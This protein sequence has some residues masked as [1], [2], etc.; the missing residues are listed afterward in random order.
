MPEFYK[1]STCRYQPAAQPYLDAIARGV[2]YKATSRAFLLEGTEYSQSYAGAKLLWRKQ[3]K[4]RDPTDSNKCPFWS[5]YF[6]EPCQSCN[7]RI[8]DSVSMEIDAI[9]F[10][11]DAEGKTLAIHIEMKRDGEP[12]KFGQSEAYRPRAECYRDQRRIRETLLA[13]NYF[14]AVLFHG[15]GTDIPL[16]KSHFDSVI[17]HECARNIFP[18]YPTG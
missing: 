10:L 7:C 18:Q 17:S 4:K 2:R 1:G 11:R 12:L 8:D 3:W 15:T 5:N 13:H 14:I 9:F 16:A 6:Y